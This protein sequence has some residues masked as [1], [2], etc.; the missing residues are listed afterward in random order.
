MSDVK[1]A[2]RRVIELLVAGDY[3]ALEELTGGDRLPRGQIE[4][5]VADYGRRLIL[6]PEETYDNLDA[7]MVAG[8]HVP[9]YSVVVPLWTAEEGMSDL[10]VSLTVTIE[11]DLAR[12]RLDDLHVL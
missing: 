6:P 5:A 1:E 9:T 4:Q 3:A 2:T 10:S 8:A 11:S 12:V 7:I